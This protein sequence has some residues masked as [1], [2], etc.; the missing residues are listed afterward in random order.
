MTPVSYDLILACVCG[1]SGFYVMLWKLHMFNMKKYTP[2]LSSMVV[3]LGVLSWSIVALASYS[4]MVQ[5]PYWAYSVGWYGSYIY[6]TSRV[7]STISWMLL[8]FHIC[9]Y[10]PKRKSE[11]KAE[12]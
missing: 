10:S 4:N 1:F 5:Q 8:L 9:K 7:L 12:I 3:L 6:T 11:V 2:V